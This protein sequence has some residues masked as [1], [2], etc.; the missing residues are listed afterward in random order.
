MDNSKITKNVGTPNQ[1][2]LYQRLGK[3]AEEIEQQPFY[4]GKAKDLAMIA[5]QMTRIYVAEIERARFEV[6]IGKFEEIREV[7]IK[8]LNQL[9]E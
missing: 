4:Y 6:E 8:A 1:K 9:N 3:Q 7:Q 5:N 2:A